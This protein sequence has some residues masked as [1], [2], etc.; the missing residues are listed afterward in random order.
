M[1][2]LN[3]FSLSFI[4][5]ALVACSSSEKISGNYNH[6]LIRGVIL[7]NL[8]DVKKCYFAELPNE[9]SMEGKLVPEWSIDETGSVLETTVFE[10]STTLKNEKVKGCILATIKT[11]K[12]PPAK[13]GELIMVRYPFVFK[14]EK[15][16]K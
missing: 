9:P 10:K 4:I 13:P 16:P 14:P 15:S 11:W 3:Y 8:N 5:F 12:F 6:N 2:K 7:A 1:D